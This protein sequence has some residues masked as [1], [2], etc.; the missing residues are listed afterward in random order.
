MSQ[1]VTFLRSPRNRA[2]PAM[3]YFSTES[4]INTKML[5]HQ[6]NG[7]CNNEGLLDTQRPSDSRP[8]NAMPS[9]DTWLWLPVI[10]MW[11]LLFWKFIPMR[12]QWACSI[13]LKESLLLDQGI[14]KGTGGN[15]SYDCYLP[16]SINGLPFKSPDVESILLY[17]PPKIEIKTIAESFQFSRFS[18]SLRLNW[19]FL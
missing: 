9:E 3:I 14:R 8:C 7:H 10:V 17:W 1:S 5:S 4:S 6:T 18:L 16:W 19:G 15:S 2:E 11:L 13:L 12:L